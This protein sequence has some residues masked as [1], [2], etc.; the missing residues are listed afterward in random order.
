MDRGLLELTQSLRALASKQDAISANLANVSSTSFKRRQGVVTPFEQLLDGATGAR[1]TV[2]AFREFSDM[3]QGDLQDTGSRFD[4]ALDGDGMFRVMDP[5]FPERPMYTRSG[6]FARGQDGALMTEDGRVL[7][8]EAGAPILVPQ[9]GDIMI[10][11][12]GEVLSGSTGDVLGRLAAWRFD[13]PAALEPL[14]A[15]LFTETT[16]SGPA[17]P[18]R[19]TRFQQGSLER[20]NVNS[21]NELVSMIATQRHFGVVMR[22]MSTTIQGGQQLA[23][24]AQ[25]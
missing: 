7:L 21:V 1:V 5:R 18:D 2:P 23:Q 11:P 20:S 3:T 4:V 24:L 16:A 15:G 9:G 10:K 22:A 17:A 8:D 25:G 6:H 13:D 12:G 19:F 14:G